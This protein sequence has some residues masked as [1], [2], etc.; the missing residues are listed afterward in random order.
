VERGGDQIKAKAILGR[1]TGD[2]EKLNECE[3]V[4]N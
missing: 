3:G 1:W 2:Y 4:F